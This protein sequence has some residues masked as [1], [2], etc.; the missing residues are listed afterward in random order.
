M[1]LLPAP[2]P[3]GH[4]AA[5]A[6]RGPVGPAACGPGRG[7]WA[8]LQ[9]GRAWRGCQAAPGPRRSAAPPPAAG[10]TCALPAPSLQTPSSLGHRTPPASPR[11][12]PPS[13]LTLTPS[14]SLQPPARPPGAVRGP[15]CRL[16]ERPSVERPL[17]SGVSPVFWSIYCTFFQSFFFVSSLAVSPPRRVKPKTLKN[18]TVYSE[19]KGLTGPPRGQHVAGPGQCRMRGWGAGARGACLG[20]VPSRPVPAGARRDPRGAAPGPSGAGAGRA[21]PDS[22]FPP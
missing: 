17:G 10:G 18:R 16:R 4:A 6:R 15:G 21:A 5:P 9:R 14:S 22:R 7:A 19:K 20:S 11:L 13:L 8:Q 12:L 2:L 3:R 1:P